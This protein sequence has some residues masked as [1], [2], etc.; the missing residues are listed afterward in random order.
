MIDADDILDQ[1]I[2]EQDAERDAVEETV[3][4]AKRIE[5]ARFEDATDS[6]YWV[7]FCFQTRAQKEQFLRALKLI[8]LGDKYID[9]LEAA[10]VLGVEV[11]E[12]TPT[13]PELRGPTARLRE[14]T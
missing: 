5:S 9:G 10:A 4:G 7:A 6:E 3:A 2:A 1:I 8:E 11:T 14:L 13:W 12:P